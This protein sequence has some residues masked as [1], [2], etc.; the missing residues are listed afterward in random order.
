M[1]HTLFYGLAAKVP[2]SHGISRCFSWDCDNFSRAK[3]LGTR[4]DT[5]F[6]RLA[7]NLGKREV[8]MGEGLA[9]RNHTET[10]RVSQPFALIYIC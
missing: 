4:M 5:G 3:P 9:R 1:R 10:R 8:F 7:A 6:S 2:Q